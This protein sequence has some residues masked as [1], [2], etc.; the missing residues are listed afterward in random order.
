MDWNKLIMQTILTKP[1]LYGLTVLLITAFCGNIF[2]QRSPK[3]LYLTVSELHAD[4]VK[5]VM[6]RQLNK[7]RKEKGLKPFR[8]DA[9]LEAVAQDFALLKGHNDTWIGSKWS[10]FDD[11]G[12]GIVDRLKQYGLFPLIESHVVQGVVNGFGENLRMKNK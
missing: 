5:M 7:L 4:T 1:G 3:N 9:R 6:F 12:N 11:E 10:H 2:A 8:Y